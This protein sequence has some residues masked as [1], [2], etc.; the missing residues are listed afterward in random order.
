VSRKE[1]IGWALTLSIGF[2]AAFFFFTRPSKATSVALTARERSMQALGQEIAKS[3]PGAKVLVLM[4]PFTKQSGFGDEKA[5]FQDAGVR[6]LR[7]GLGGRAEVTPVFPAL[8]Q[9]YL[10][11]P[12]SLVIPSESR[13]PLSFLVDARS[14]EQL[15]NQH[16]NATVIVSL[17]GLPIGIDSLKLWQKSDPR[18]FALLLPDLKVLGRPEDTLLA[19]DNGKLL[20]IIG[21]EANAGDGLLITKGNAR[22]MLRT[23]PQALGF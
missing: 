22:E 16:S 1:V 2:A 23:K 4:N 15:A 7:R 6:G 21:E 13:T 12:S 3:R 9:E 10:Q 20:A 18:S 19:F 11:N 8:R 14:V 17:I 5:Q